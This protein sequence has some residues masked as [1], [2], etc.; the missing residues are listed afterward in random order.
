MVI[1]HHVE[2]IVTHVTDWLDTDAGGAI[3]FERL[4][5]SAQIRA[6]KNK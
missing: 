2:N 3:D 5:A 6:T 1:A 4:L